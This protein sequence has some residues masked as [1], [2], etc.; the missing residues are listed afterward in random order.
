MLIEAPDLH[1][2]WGEDAAVGLRRFAE[3][4]DWLLALKDA[5]RI[6]EGLR[7]WVPELSSG[8]I[9]WGACEVL[10]VRMRDG[11]WTA[12]CRLELDARG[13]PRSV[14]L[15][16]HYLPEDA[17]DVPLPGSND[18]PFASMQW[19]CYVPELRLRFELLPGDAALT[20]LP[21][22]TEPEEAR[23][24]LERC[25]RSASPVYADVRIESCEPRIT[26]YKPGR[27]CTVLYQL[28][29]GTDGNGDELP[30]PVVAK[31]HHGVK[32]RNAHESMR[33]LWGSPLRDSPTVTIS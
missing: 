12:Q 31:T 13:G 27:R 32:G 6:S 5:E 4:P 20:S 1:A 23:S 17:T 7:A 21:A 10:R 25:M 2:A 9:D 33:A 3:P 24:I 29:Y 15:A 26:R 8:E 19:S 30:N 11:R 22:L 16:A 14:D 28:T 18:E